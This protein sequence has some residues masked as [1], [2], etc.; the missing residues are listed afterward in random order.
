MHCCFALG[1][2]ISGLSASADSSVPGI[3]A[4]HLQQLKEEQDRLEQAL[5]LPPAFIATA[6]NETA[7]LADQT[8]TAARTLERRMVACQSAV[9]LFADPLALAFVNRFSDYLFILARHL[10]KGNHETVDYTLLDPS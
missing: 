5:T 10:E 7:A 8:A 4:T 3:R 9:P 1:A 2:Q 6:T